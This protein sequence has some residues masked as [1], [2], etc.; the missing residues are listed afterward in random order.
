MSYLHDERF[1]G[2]ANENGLIVSLAEVDYALSTGAT[3]RI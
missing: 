2:P 3:S 1:D